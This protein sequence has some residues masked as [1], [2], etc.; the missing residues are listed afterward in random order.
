M[1]RAITTA[2]MALALTCG[3]ASAYDP[4]KAFRYPAPDLYRPNVDGVI[5]RGNGTSGPIG[6]ACV[7]VNGGSIC[8]PLSTRWTDSQVQAVDFGVKC[9]GTTDDSP[10]IMAATNMAAS[11][12]GRDV[13]FPS[14]ATCRLNTGM[15][16]PSRTRWV[17]RGGTVLYLDPG[18]ATYTSIAGAKRG[19]AFVNVNDILI[20]GITFNGGGSSTTAAGDCNA[21]SCPGI[22]ANNV[23]NAIIRNSVFQNFGS[24]SAYIQGLVVFGGGGWLIDKSSFV[25]TSGDNLAFSNATSNVEV[26]GSFF[27]GT[28][29]D[30]ALVCTIG[31]TNFGFHDNT[32]VGTAGN[33]APLVVMDRCNN[34]S[35][36]NNRITLPDNSAVAVRVARYGN[37]PETNHDF[38]ISGNTIQGGSRAISV[39]SSSTQQGSYTVG[40]GGRFT[41]SGNVAVGSNV[42]IGLSDSEAGSVTGNTCAGA[43]DTGILVESGNAGVN[44]GNVAISGNNISAT[45]F[46]IRQIA[47]PGQ[48][49]P[50]SLGANNISFATTPIQLAVQQAPTVIPQGAPSAAKC[51]P[52]QILGVDTSFLYVCPAYGVLGKVPLTTQAQ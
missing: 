40:G 9:D 17:S 20:D 27:S 16:P 13:I 10:A 36:H 47:G 46:G 12:G 52:G 44:S 3:S 6:G 31:G 19:I 37:T 14:N 15:A 43:T 23:N 24:A 22:A 32:I 34:W 49:L 38:T 48:S 39:E 25:N 42:C 26:R 2:L 41:V 35:V 7:Q 5:F 18:M 30:S 4:A 33:A 1:I 45:N 8:R 51:Q 21:G 11:L 28:A 50:L 29:R